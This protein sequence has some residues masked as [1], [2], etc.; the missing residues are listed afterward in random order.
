LIATIRYEM[1]TLWPNGIRLAG[2]EQHLLFRV[3]EKQLHLSLDNIE[4]VLYIAVAMPRHCLCRR[5]LKFCDAESWPFGMAKPTIY[6]I[7]MTSVLER[8]HPSSF[9]PPNVFNMC[10]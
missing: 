3:T 6:F 2:A 9:M 1:W 7:E 4:C 5:D 10:V 8:L